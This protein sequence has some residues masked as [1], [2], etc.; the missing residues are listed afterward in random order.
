MAFFFR[1]LRNAGDEDGEDEGQEVALL[2][3]TSDSGKHKAT[4]VL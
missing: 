1:R 2:E 3:D 4:T